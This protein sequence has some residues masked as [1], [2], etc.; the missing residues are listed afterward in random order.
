VA[1]VAPPDLFDP[2]F[3]ANASIDTKANE[4]NIA[5]IDIDKT[6]FI[7]RFP[8]GYLLLKKFFAYSKTKQKMRQKNSF[9]KFHAL[10]YYKIVILY[11]I[12][13]KF[14]TKKTVIALYRVLL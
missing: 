9:I 2:P 8:R 1:E 13:R 11:C 14:D 3:A 12:V 5:A 10:K 6:G 4:V 7:C